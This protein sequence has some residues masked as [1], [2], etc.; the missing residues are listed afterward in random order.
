MEGE[1]QGLRDEVTSLEQEKKKLE[2]LK[3]E[4][5]QPEFAERELREK[6][7]YGREGETIVVLPEPEESRIRNQKSG[8]ESEENLE[9]WERWLGVFGF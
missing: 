5:S 3:I 7:G 1:I 4:A 6:L 9:N 2:A 8:N